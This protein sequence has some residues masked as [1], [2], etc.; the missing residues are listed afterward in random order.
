MNGNFKDIILEDVY[1]E[2]C[3]RFD[4]AACPPANKQQNKAAAKGGAASSPAKR[5]PA[6]PKPPAPPAAPKPKAKASKK[7][8]SAS[9]PKAKKTASK[10]TLD[11]EDSD[12]EMSEPRAAPLGDVSNN[13]N[14]SSKKSKGKKTVEETYKQMSQ[15]EHILL[16]PDT[17]SKYSCR[18]FQ[19]SSFVL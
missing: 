1:D 11:L 2:L 4:Y 6:A 5:Q 8:V 14:A 17:Y 9:K 7:T 16:R 15:L 12:V 3:D 10:K 13:A 19:C 18:E